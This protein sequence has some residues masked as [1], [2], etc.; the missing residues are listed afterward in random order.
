MRILVVE[1]DDQVANAVREALRVSGHYSFHCNRLPDEPTAYAQA[2]L[3][4]LDLD[5]PDHE[6]GLE[7]LRRFRSVSAIPV[8]ALATTSVESAVVRGLRTGAD[9]Y[10]VKPIRL[11]ELLA[12]IDAIRRRVL[13]PI[14]PLE[15]VI[16]VDDVAIDLVARTVQAG[17]K[18]IGLTLK[19]FDILA[20]VARR[21]GAAISRRELRD[22]VWGDSYV[23]ASR[24]LDVHITTLRAKLRRPGLLR[25]IHGFGYSFG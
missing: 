22:E 13:T 7:V 1:D 9:D 5:L 23:V 2:D 25:T 4:I 19:E 10:L 24:S 6:D 15:R 21:G 16:K 14:V 18:T 3:M 8:L 12:R 17:E 11:G 20:A